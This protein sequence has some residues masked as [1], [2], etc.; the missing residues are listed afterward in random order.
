MSTDMNNTGEDIPAPLT[1][2][3]AFRSVYVICPTDYEWDTETEVYYPSGYNSPRHVFESKPKADN[4]LLNLTFEFLEMEDSDEG[5]ENP[6]YALR[7]FPN[8][9]RSLSYLGKEFDGDDVDQLVAIRSLSEK[10]PEIAFIQFVAYAKDLPDWKA[11]KL[12]YKTQIT[13]Y[14]IFKMNIED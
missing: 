11:L 8:M 12:F 1:V 7:Y 3:A 6:A 2:S 5:P 4:K 9:F 13:P 10:D 14:Y